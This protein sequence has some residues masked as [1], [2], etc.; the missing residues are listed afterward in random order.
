MF[1]IPT[2]DICEEKTLIE[3]I[4]VG[5]VTVKKYKISKNN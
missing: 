2:Y 4:L 5:G 1:I 3:K